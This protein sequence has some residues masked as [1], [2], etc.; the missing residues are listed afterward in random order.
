MA[1]WRRT[2][3]EAGIE[4]LRLPS[5]GKLRITRTGICIGIEWGAAVESLA[6]FRLGS[7]F[8]SGAGLANIAPTMDLPL[9]SKEFSQSSGGIEREHETGANQE[10]VETRGTQL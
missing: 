1:S 10:G 5:S 8:R 2:L 6:K 9:V 7:A 4:I 3:L